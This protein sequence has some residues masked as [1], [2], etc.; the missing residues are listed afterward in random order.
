[1]TYEYIRVTHGWHTSTYEQHTDDIRI[2]TSD[3]RMTYEYIWVTYGWHTSTYEWNTNDI[4]VHIGK[5]RWLIE[6]LYVRKFLLSKYFKFYG[7]EDFTNPLLLW[8]FSITKYFNGH[9]SGTDL[10]WKTCGRKMVTWGKVL[11]LATPR[12]AIIGKVWLLWVFRSL[13]NAYVAIVHLTICWV[14]LTNI[15]SPNLK[16]HV[17]LYRYLYIL[18]C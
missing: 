1:M 13:D 7:F 2:H 14:K 15:L 16:V 4:R 18:F 12:G 17:L 6:G 10:K 11:S 9:L 8:N 3:I 5:T